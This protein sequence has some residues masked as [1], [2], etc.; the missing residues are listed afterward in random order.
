[1]RVNTALTARSV[2]IRQHLCFVRPWH[3]LSRR[4][5]HYFRVMSWDDQAKEI[6]SR[7]S[8]FCCEILSKDAGT[9]WGAYNSKLSAND[10]TKIR[11]ALKGES[12]GFNLDGDAARFVVLR[13]E[14]DDKKKI[15][16]A[17]KQSQ[18]VIAAEYFS[19][20]TI[21]VVLDDPDNRLRTLRTNFETI[22]DYYSQFFTS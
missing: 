5:S 7:S 4:F 20:G 3:G 19:G 17:K 13:T 1:M 6:A 16:V 10:R 11:A 18:C 8:A 12:A 9:P 15:L 2:R 21:L 14:E 22:G